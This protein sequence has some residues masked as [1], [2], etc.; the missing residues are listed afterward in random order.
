M[1]YGAITSPRIDSATDL[2]PVPGDRMLS[3]VAQDDAFIGFDLLSS[4]FWVFAL[5]LSQVM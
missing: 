5:L 4:I 3:Q 1:L 2:R